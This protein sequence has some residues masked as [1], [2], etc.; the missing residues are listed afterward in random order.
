MKNH[1]KSFIALKKA[2]S[3]LQ[4]VMKMMEE[5][6]YCIDIIQQNLAIMG[7]LRAANLNLL[8]NHVNCCVTDAAKKGGRELMEKMDELIKVLKIA[9]S[10]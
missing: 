1:N 4:K 7:L 5:E 8:E 3:L 2:A 9:Q 10:K 6:K